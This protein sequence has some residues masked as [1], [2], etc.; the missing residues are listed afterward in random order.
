MYFE[1]S[2]YLFLC[3]V[4]KSGISKIQKLNVF[5]RQYET[6]TGQGLSVIRISTECKILA[7][8]SMNIFLNFAPHR[9]KNVD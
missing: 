4:E 6:L 1:I 9:I 8:T 3:T 5:D 7:K 2:I